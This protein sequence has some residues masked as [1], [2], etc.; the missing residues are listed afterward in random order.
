MVTNAFGIVEVDHVS[1]PVDTRKLLDT[2]WRHQENNY[3]RREI[4]LIRGV[5][6]AQP[7][8]QVTAENIDRMNNVRG[9]ETEAMGLS[10]GGILPP[11]MDCVFISPGSHT[12]AL[13]IRNGAVLDILSTFT[14]EIN[15]AIRKE[16]ILGGE[17]T[18]GQVKME[19]EHVLRGFGHL[20]RYGFSRAIYIIHATKVFG[21]A[22]DAIRTQ[23]LEGI[24]A[25]STALALKHRIEQEWQNVGKIVIKGGSPYMEAY[26]LLCRHLMPDI[27][28]ILYDPQDNPSLALSGFLHM[29]SLRKPPSGIKI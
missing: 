1:T 14:G 28:T 23:M 11:D 8:Q 10:A 20:S 21:V 2:A 18:S 27:D 17:L 9:E 16:T 24:I 7:G 29:L 13:L 26:L 25:G 5:K 4:V 3:F 15:H 12:H 19:P 22:D 6:T